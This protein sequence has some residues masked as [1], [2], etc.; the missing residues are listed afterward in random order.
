MSSHFNPSTHGQGLYKLHVR[1]VDYKPI[2]SQADSKVQVREADYKLL[3][4][5]KAD[6]TNFCCLQKADNTNFSSEWPI[7]C[8]LLYTVYQ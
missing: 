3:Q 4:S 7:Y 8:S 5:Q 2:Q 1:K 6:T